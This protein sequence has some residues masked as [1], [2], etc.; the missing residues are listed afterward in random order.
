MHPTKRKATTGTEAALHGAFSSSAPT[1]ATCSIQ[2]RDQ[3]ST[4]GVEGSVFTVSKTNG[5]LLVCAL[6]CWEH[7]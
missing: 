2:S 5:G 1:F 4:A 3:R 6:F 7:S